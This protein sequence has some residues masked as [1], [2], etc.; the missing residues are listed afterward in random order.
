MTDDAAPDFGLLPDHPL[1]FFG[2]STPLERDA[3]K[4]AYTRL[5][6]RF[7]PDHHPEEFMRIRA[8][9]EQLDDRLR[10][11]EGGG[12]GAPS[13]APPRP[14]DTGSSGRPPGSPTRGGAPPESPAPPPLDAAALV[15]E[16]GPAAARSRLADDARRHPAAWCAVALLDDVLSSEAL[17]MHRAL[18]EGA[19]VSGG[20]HAVLSLLYA[21]LREELAPKDAAAV[22]VGL[23]EATAG[24]GREG[25][26]SPARYWYLTD[27]VWVGLVSRVRFAAFQALLER[28]ARLVGEAGRAGWLVLLVRLRRRAMLLAD[29]AWLRKVDGELADGARELAPWIVREHDLALWF[30]RYRE[31]RDTFLDGDPLRGALDRALAAIVTGDEVEAD[32]AF[33]GAMIECLE[34]RDELF[35]ALPTGAEGVDLAVELLM[36]YGE[37]WL[38]SA[39]VTQRDGA[40]MTRRALEFAHRVDKR[41]DRALVGRLFNLTL[42]FVYAMLIVLAATAGLLTAPWI[43]EE[44]AALVA[45][46]A[47]IGVVFAFRRGVFAPLVVRLAPPFTRR[48]H[49]RVWRPMTADFLRDTHMPFHALVAL[50]RTK[51]AAV[52]GFEFE[53]IASD[54][55]LC[56]YS[57]AVRTV[58]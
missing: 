33:L 55:G 36:W 19:R 1:E 49:R 12:F 41:S 43:G 8:A 53:G 52:D 5:V 18:I 14:P 57:L 21:L 48:L 26:F 58:G 15:R 3:L 28:C 17:A 13:S 50:L 44:A 42:L 47:L 40:T 39:D 32:R 23:A 38:E 34:R 20:D 54:R 31:V 22:L 37:G 2:L 9:Y 56:V 10:Y 7:K 25:G 4:R 30:D 16:L 24:N 35:A 27:H 51:E 6:R 29:D 45:L 11:A 46:A